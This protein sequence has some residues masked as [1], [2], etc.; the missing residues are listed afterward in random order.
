MTKKTHIIYISIIAA[1]LSIIYSNT[2]TDG[3]NKENIQFDTIAVA[4]KKDSTEYYRNIIDSDWS[5]KQHFT[6]IKYQDSTLTPE[7]AIRFMVECN[8]NDIDINLGV[9]LKETGMTAGVAKTANNL[10]GLKKARKRFSWADGWTSSNYCQ[11]QN[12]YF[13]FLEMNE[14]LMSGSKVWS[15]HYISSKYKKQIDSLTFGK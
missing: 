4:N 3:Y 12:P 1:V 13:S 5:L 7:T 14:Y 8:L 9:A 11:F 2:Q 10:H 15:S 6:A